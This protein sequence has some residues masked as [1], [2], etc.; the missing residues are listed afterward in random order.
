MFW[1]G[2][3]N[4]SRGRKILF[5]GTSALAFTGSA[6]YLQQRSKKRDVF[7]E[8]DPLRS[9]GP[10]KYTQYPSSTIALD[11]SG[12]SEIDRQLHSLWCPPSR[13]ELIEKLKQSAKDPSQEFD[14]LV[15]G[16]GATGAGVALDAAARGLKVALV[17]RDDYSAGELESLVTIFSSSKM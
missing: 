13:E 2:L 16:G 11:N 7:S 14:L 12:A 10:N 6:F 17:E 5:G 8:L 15:V 9:T 1:R 3:S 4:L